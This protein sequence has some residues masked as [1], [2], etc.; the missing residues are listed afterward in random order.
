VSRARSTTARIIIAASTVGAL[1]FGAGSD[2][3]T[4]AATQDTPTS[5]TATSAPT[6]ESVTT[7]EPGPATTGSTTTAAPC[8]DCAGD[9]T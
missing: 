7:T 5:E 4:T 1:L 6:T 8:I 2:W 3:A 9:R